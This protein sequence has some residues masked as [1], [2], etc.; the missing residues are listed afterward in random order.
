M[1]GVLI[2]SEEAWLR[3]L[4][5]AGRRFRG[6]PVTREEFAPTF[7]QGTAE[8][9]QGARRLLERVEVVDD[10]VHLRAW[11]TPV[12]TSTRTTL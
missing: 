8:P 10:G 3:V 2:R 4:E 6:S 9:S 11:M 12:A 7:G 5:D 1:D